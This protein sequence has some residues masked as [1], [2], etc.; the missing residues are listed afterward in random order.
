MCSK[1]FEFALT[2]D[3]KFALVWISRYKIVFLQNFEDIALVSLAPSVA[4]EK[5]VAN[6][7]LVSL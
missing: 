5:S 4:D 1:Y 6:L 2:L 3:C 7:P